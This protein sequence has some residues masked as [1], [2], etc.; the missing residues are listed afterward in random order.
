M[1]QAKIKFHHGLS[2]FRH[3]HHHHHHRH[4]QEPLPAD[5][6]A[7]TD[8]LVPPICA[9]NATGWIRGIL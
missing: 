9:C 1:S 5:G 4:H 2:K 8:V 7:D 6:V 3:G